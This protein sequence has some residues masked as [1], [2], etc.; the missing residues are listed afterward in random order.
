MFQIEDWQFIIAIFFAGGYIVRHEYAHRD[1][2]RRI[3]E[4]KNYVEKRINN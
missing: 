4:L 2:C 1:L 3:T